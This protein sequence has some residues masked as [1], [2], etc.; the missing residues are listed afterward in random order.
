MWEHLG[1]PFGNLMETHWEPENIPTVPTLV[2]KSK[3]K[4]NWVYWVH[5]AIPHW[6][7]I[8][9]FHHLFWPKL[10]GHHELCGDIW[11][12]FS[13][14]QTLTKVVFYKNIGHL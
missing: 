11:K 9:C 1:E 2:P 7:S 13:I 10:M 8:V 6:V 4:K 12:S 3:K 14:T 5:V